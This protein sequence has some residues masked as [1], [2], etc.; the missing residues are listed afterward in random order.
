M[1]IASVIWNG[2]QLALALLREWYIRKGRKQVITEIN[3]KA[4][5]NDRITSDIVN[6][7]TSVADTVDNL[8]SGRF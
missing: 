8:E 6:T 1:K 5:E 3:E 4:A 7:G 2:I